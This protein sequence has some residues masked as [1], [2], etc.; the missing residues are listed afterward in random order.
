MWAG[1]GLALKIPGG[2]EWGQGQED[3]PSRACAAALVLSAGE[4]AL[5][6]QRGQ[7]HPLQDTLH[8]SS[9]EAGAGQGGS[10]NPLL[11]HE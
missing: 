3:P 4:E 8:D 5:P 10:G 6:S 11:A 1:V 2:N 9:T 7:S